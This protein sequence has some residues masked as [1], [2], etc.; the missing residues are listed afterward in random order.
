MAGQ[1]RRGQ[2]QPPAGRYPR[3]RDALAGAAR[4]ARTLVARAGARTR[5]GHR[6]LRRSRPAADG[7]GAA[8]AGR[9]GHDG[10][11][12]GD[13]RAGRAAARARPVQP[14]RLA[15]RAAR[16]AAR[17]DAR[18][19]LRRRPRRYL[20][21]LGDDAGGTGALPRA[22]RRLH[23]RSAGR[24]S[25]RR[26]R[27]GHHRMDQPDR[28]RSPP[29]LLRRRHR[30][31]V[32]RPSAERRLHAQRPRLAGH[33]ATDVSP[34][35][36]GA[37]AGAQPQLAAA[38]DAPARL[39]LRR[40]AARRRPPRRPA[41]RGPAAPRR[42]PAGAAGRHAHHDLDAR[43]SRELAVPLPLDGARVAAAPAAGR[44]PQRR[45]PRAARPPR[46]TRRSGCRDWCS[47]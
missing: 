24:R 34:R 1:P 19:A 10:R 9:R 39:L 33:R 44:A 20:S 37:V 2:R 45:S 14:R 3:R 15:V 4:R 35:R 16:R 30:R 6:G 47:A 32:H 8:P 7:A 17:G 23:R 13:Q 22:R 43:A 42:H 31:G 11:G 41:R 12:V 40:R 36:A 29:D 28:R 27:A 46:A 26:S 25:R 21:L 5:P 18:G 38:P